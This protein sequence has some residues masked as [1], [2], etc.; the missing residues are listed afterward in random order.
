MARG[1]SFCECVCARGASISDQIYTRYG[2]CARGDAIGDFIFSLVSLKI[3]AC[4]RKQGSNALQMRYP[5]SMSHG[6]IKIVL[7]LFIFFLN[8]R[9]ARL[10]FGHSREGA[11]A[12]LGGFGGGGGGGCTLRPLDP[13][14][15]VS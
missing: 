10:S 11:N 4:E 13:P 15:N 2:C 9:L 5:T 14:L 12:S 8:R 1:R 7:I 3:G 6:T